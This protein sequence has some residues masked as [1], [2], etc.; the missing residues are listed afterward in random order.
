MS[1]Q[2]LS[3]LSIALLTACNSNNKDA[4]STA[5]LKPIEVKYPVTK[6]DSSV[7]DN[8][9]GMDVSDPYRWLE[10]DTSAETGQWVKNE[11]NVTQKFLEQIPFREDIRKRYTSLFNYEKF[12]APSREGKYNYYNKN[13]GLQNQ[14]VIYRELITGSAPEVFL[15]PNTFSK[16]GTTSLS[17]INFS[18]DGSFAAYNI[19]EGGSDWQK[20]IVMDAIAK[21]Q[22]GDTMMDIKFSGSSWKGN[23]GFYYSTYDRPK[24]GSFLQGKTE[25]HKLYYH[26]LGTTQKEDK[27]IYGGDGPAIRYIGAGVSEDQKWLFIYASTATYGNALYVQDLTKPNA[28]IVTMVGDMKNQHGV[29]DTDDA[30][31]YIQTDRDAPNS[32]IMVVPFSNPAES[33]WKVLVDSK[34]EVLNTSAAGG[35]I[36]CSYLKDAVSKVYQYDRTGKQIREI[37]LPG[38]GTAGGFFGKRDEKDVFFYFAS[39]V[40]PTTIYKLNIESGKSDIYKQPKVEFKPEEYESKQVF[41]TSKDGTKIPMIITYK[42]GLEMNGKN[43]CLLYAYG[44]FSVSITPYFSTS[45]IILLEN[46]GIYAVPNIRGGGEYGEAWHQGGIKTKK[47]NVFDDFAAAANY[48]VENK[49]TS[50]D[51]LAIEGG[52]NG[53]LLVG[54]TITQHPD[55]CKVAFPAVGVLDMLRYHKFTSGAGWAYDYGTSEDSKEMFDYLHKYSPVHNAK[56]ASYPATMVTTADHDDRVVPAHSFKFAAAMQENQKGPNPVLIRIE[57]KAG[58]GAGKST[59]QIIDEQ[60]DKWSFMFYNMGVSP[61]YEKKKLD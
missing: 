10:N 54:A 18:H 21:K 36:Y 9:F 51:K 7:K 61:K 43:P 22:L 48:L 12:S 25:R 5:A 60:T 33:N 13:S 50:H 37:N 8:Y 14:S 41:Y 42:K 58:H 20:I 27:L 55:I 11:N 56:P 4:E 23:E 24:E 47:Q 35:Y 31:F 19:S 26:Q 38:P 32:K 34:P 2:L 59:Q 3:I 49:Y 57:T 28:P 52:S 53:G 40:N 1:K 6:K 45:A 15:D 29:I 39:Y 46:G 16:D 17:G 30:N 44:G